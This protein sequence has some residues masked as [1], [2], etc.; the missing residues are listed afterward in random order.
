MLSIYKSGHSE[1]LETP[2]ERFVEVCDCL[3]AGV[4]LLVLMK[5]TDF[6]EVLD[7]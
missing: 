1:V 5:L 4:E 7:Q 6:D 3:Y 2:S